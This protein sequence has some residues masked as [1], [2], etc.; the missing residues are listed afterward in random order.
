MTLPSGY[1]KG[2]LIKKFAA[3]GPYIREDKCDVDRFFFDCLAVCT[4]VKP[5]PEKR[6]FWGWWM[7]LNAEEM[8]F[9]YTWQFG[10]FDKEGIWQPAI[11]K[12][13][14]VEEQITQTL[15]NFYGRLEDLLISLNFELIPA[16]G[17]EQ[18]IK[19]R[20]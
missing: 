4:D 14:E 8:C 3:L 13:S 19:R 9:H 17:S 5:D 16:E 15:H 11:F 6:E 2:R 12:D 7:E 18:F 20:A 10:L 1:P